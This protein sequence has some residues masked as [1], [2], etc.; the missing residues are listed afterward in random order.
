MK[1]RE[2]KKGSRRRGLGVVGPGVRRKEAS[3]Q[4]LSLTVLVLPPLGARTKPSSRKDLL[5]PLLL[6]LLLLPFRRLE[7]ALLPFP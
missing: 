7:S 5:A 1:W 4:R 3:R 2:W 6:L